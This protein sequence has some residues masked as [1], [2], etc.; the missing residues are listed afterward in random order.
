MT[1]DEYLRTFGINPDQISDPDIPL[2]RRQTGDAM[3]ELLKRFGLHT[4]KFPYFDKPDVTASQKEFAFALN[5][6]GSDRESILVL[7]D[8]KMLSYLKSTSKEAGLTRIFCTWDTVHIRIFETTNNPAWDTMSP[9]VLSDILTLT[10]KG[11]HDARPIIS[12]TVIANNMF[13]TQAENGARI[14]DVLIK[15]EKEGFYTGKMIHEAK[16]FK[17]RYLNKTEHNLDTKSIS[18][19]WK[20]WKHKEG[21]E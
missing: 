5:E 15:F 4:R 2:L 20:S 18:S 13:R 19:A 3:R 12:P 21:L 7:H 6:A 9:H 16:R 1:F 14:W 17:E 11:G 10:S 8:A